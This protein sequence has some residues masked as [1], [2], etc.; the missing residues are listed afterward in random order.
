MEVWEHNMGE[1][2]GYGNSYPVQ[3]A[4]YAVQRRIVGDPVFLWWSATTSLES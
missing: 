1:P 3:M 4:E 2:Q